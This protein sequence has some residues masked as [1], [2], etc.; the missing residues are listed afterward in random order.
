MADGTSTVTI[1]ADDVELPGDLTLPAGATALV[2][3]AHGSGSSRKSPRNRFVAET[4]QQG[5][6]GTLL[7]DLLTPSEHE[8]DQA[9]RALRFD[10]PLLARRLT[11]TVDWLAGEARTAELTLGLFGASTGAAAALIAAAQ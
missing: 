3:F 6:L 2:V 9:D 4:L 1:H 8:R 7:F 5:G 11:A 10:I